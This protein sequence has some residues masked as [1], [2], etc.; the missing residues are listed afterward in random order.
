M[1]RIN[2]NSLRQTLNASIT[3]TALNACVLCIS[4]LPRSFNSYVIELFSFLFLFLSY[5]ITIDMQSPYSSRNSSRGIFCSRTL[6]LRSISAIGYDMD[7]TLMHYNVMV[8][9]FLFTSI[10]LLFNNIFLDVNPK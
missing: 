3:R 4:M 10:P 1:L 5:D 6:N 8:I 7:Y 9:I 2:L